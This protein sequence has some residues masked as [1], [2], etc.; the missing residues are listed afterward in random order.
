MIVGHLSEEK[1]T[2]EQEIEPI[3][4]NLGFVVKTSRGRRITDK[5]IDYF[6]K[7]RGKNVKI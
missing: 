5:G 1:D 4:I 6:K 3:L 2:L 7:I